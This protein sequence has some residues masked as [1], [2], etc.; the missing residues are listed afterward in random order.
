[1]K[2]STVNPLT[3]GKESVTLSNAMGK[4]AWVVITVALVAA[5]QNILKFVGIKSA[6][7]IDTSLDPLVQPVTTAPVLPVYETL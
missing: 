3:G 7:R 2:L 5:G 6:G 4:I 1:M